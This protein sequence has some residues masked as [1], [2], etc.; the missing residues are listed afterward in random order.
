MVLCKAFLKKPQPHEALKGHNTSAMGE[1]HRYFQPRN[2][3]S[4]SLSEITF[5]NVGKFPSAIFK[6]E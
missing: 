2:P 4:Q 6:M 1:A 5:R 3:H